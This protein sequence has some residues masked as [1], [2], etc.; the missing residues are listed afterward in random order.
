MMWMRV[1]LADDQP[2]VRFALRVLL[3]QQPGLT[4]VGEAA[5]GEEAVELVARLVPDL[6]LMDVRLG[7]GIDGLEATRRI[8]ALGLS[9]RVIMLSLHDMPA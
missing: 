4:V 7:D 9:S 5:S 8:V 1:L 3:E 2:R 6:V